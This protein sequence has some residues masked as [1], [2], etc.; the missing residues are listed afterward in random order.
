MLGVTLDQVATTDGGIDDR[1]ALGEAAST[2]DVA[3]NIRLGA[4][5]VSGH[6]AN[7]GFG[8]WAF[9]VEFHTMNYCTKRAAL[10]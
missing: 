9:S 3:G 2:G 7:D 10:L 6:E 1:I 8:V 4:A 5:W